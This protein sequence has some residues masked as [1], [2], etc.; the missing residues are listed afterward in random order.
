MKG[1][2]SSMTSCSAVSAIAQ[3]SGETAS[4]PSR[5]ALAPP[6]IPFRSAHRLPTWSP[7]WV[8][9]PHRK[10]LIWLNQGAMTLENFSGLENCNLAQGFWSAEKP[11]KEACS[12]WPMG[13][14]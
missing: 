4:S 5:N 10:V 8:T 3:K 12:D 14:S 13:A 6:P 9:P 7:C 2:S 1:T 11:R